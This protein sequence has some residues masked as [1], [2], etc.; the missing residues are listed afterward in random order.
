MNI[1]QLNVYHKLGVSNLTFQC[2]VFL[3]FSFKCKNT[4]SKIQYINSPVTMKTKCEHNEDRYA[5]N[6]P[7]FGFS[8]IFTKLPFASW[9]LPDRCISG[10]AVKSITVWQFSPSKRVLMCNTVRH[11]ELHTRKRVHDSGRIIHS[12]NVVVL[13]HSAGEIYREVGEMLR[14]A[15][16]SGVKLLRDGT[17]NMRFDRV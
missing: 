2:G 17:Q 14:T 7:D 6:Y 13:Q 11:T 3:K 8:L 16:N 1:N 5:Y 15:R 10:R 4:V 9:C 12:D